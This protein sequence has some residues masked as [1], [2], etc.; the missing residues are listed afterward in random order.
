VVPV[1]V[2]ICLPVFSFFTIFF[3]ILIYNSDKMKHICVALLHLSFNESDTDLMS[4]LH[5]FCVSSVLAPMVNWCCITVGHKPGAE[6]SD[7]Y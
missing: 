6:L 5:V 4:S 2:V 7:C 1:V 3:V